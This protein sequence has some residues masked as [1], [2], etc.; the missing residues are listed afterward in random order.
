MRIKHVSNSISALSG[1]ALT[2]EKT[3]RCSDTSYRINDLSC[4]IYIISDNRCKNIKAARH[5]YTYV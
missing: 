2:E 5:T 3:V 1:S 4:Y